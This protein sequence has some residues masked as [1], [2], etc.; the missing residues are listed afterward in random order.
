M[1]Q[2]SVA[3]HLVELL[4]NPGT[5]E[6]AFKMNSA[7][8][9]L[10]LKKNGH[11]AKFYELLGEALLRR[12]MFQ[13]LSQIYA[14]LIEEVKANKEFLII[15]VNNKLRSGPPA[16]TGRE[17]ADTYPNGTLYCPQHQYL[18]EANAVFIS[19]PAMVPGQ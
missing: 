7:L 13:K 15:L 10:D 3:R 16:G 18:Q 6:E 14:P 17:R 9:A 12:M 4:T 11:A 8:K 1:T 19:M 2:S 5:P